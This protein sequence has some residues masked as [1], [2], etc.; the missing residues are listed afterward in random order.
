MGATDSMSEAHTLLQ[1]SAADESPTDADT[2]VVRYNCVSDEHVLY[3]AGPSSKKPRDLAGGGR[4]R[5]WAHERPTVDERC[6]FCV[7]KEPTC[8]PCV[9][10]LE[11][12]AGEWVCRVFENK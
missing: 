1:P 12:D 10:T 6:P 3:I 2:M 7:G 11:N 5:P 9:A 4:S 8:L